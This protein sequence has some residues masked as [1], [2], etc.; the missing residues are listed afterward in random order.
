MVFINEFNFCTALKI[1]LVIS[2]L[3]LQSFMP[4]VRKPESCA[5]KPEYYGPNDFYIGS[6]IDIFGTRFVITEADEF[7]VKY[8]EAHRDKFSDDLIENLFSRVAS[9]T[10]H[11]DGKDARYCKKGGAA[12]LQ[13]S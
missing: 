11:T 2:K 6:V 13:R 8:M 9:D 10:V 4:R 7:V 12:N 5:E 1:F 3:F